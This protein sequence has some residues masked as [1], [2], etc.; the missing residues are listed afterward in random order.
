MTPWRLVAV[1]QSFD[2]LYRQVI[3]QVLTAFRSP[4]SADNTGPVTESYSVTWPGR[5]AGQ[6]YDTCVLLIFIAPLWVEK[7]QG[8][9]VRAEMCCTWDKDTFLLTYPQ[10]TSTMIANRPFPFLP[11]EFRCRCDH[12]PR[13]AFAVRWLCCYPKACSCSRWASAVKTISICVNIV[14]GKQREA[15]NCGPNFSF[16]FP[17]LLLGESIF[18]APAPGD[19][20]KT[21]TRKT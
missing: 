17:S 1:Y 15:P 4:P 8:M 14:E 16:S 19:D 13:T 2:R 9:L 12:L 5:D 7:S 11:P 10:T 6:Q 21:H 18:S 20:G 3:V